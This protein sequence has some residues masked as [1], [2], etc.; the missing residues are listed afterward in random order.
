MSAEQIG[1]SRLH[2]PGQPAPGTPQFR[3]MVVRDAKGN[4]FAMPFTYMAALDENA[5]KQ[6]YHVV[7]QAVT[8]ANRDM[9]AGLAA[10]IVAAFQPQPASVPVDD[11]NPDRLCAA[12]LATGMC[13]KRLA[14]HATEEHPFVPG[15]QMAGEDG[16][17]QLD[18]A[19]PPEGQ[20]PASE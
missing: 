17:A 8:D 10:M 18:I 19:P 4:T 3:H 14:D 20:E 9:I 13:N 6:I 15:A 5:S 1:A 16:V 12:A 7:R 11:E 2:L